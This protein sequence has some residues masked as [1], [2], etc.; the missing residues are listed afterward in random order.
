MANN[1]NLKRGNP[2]TEF[3]SGRKAVESGR[4]GGKKSG[5]SK[6][7]KK[8]FQTLMNEILNSS[9]ADNPQL[10]KMAAQLGLDSDAHIKQL[11]TMVSVLNTLKKGKT[12]DIIE[13]ATFLGE[14][15]KSSNKDILD[16]LDDVL[17]NIESGF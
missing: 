3:K 16:K 5:E 8:T 12:A 1:G 17:K 11:M 2:D 14:V 7:A 10:K 9:V 6:R 15:E 4:K 13:M